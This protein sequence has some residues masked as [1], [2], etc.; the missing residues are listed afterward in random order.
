MG[1][2]VANFKTDGYVIT[3]AVEDPIT[4]ENVSA[5]IIKENTPI[6]F[7]FVNKDISA[8][9]GSV[10]NLYYRKYKGKNIIIRSRDFPYIPTTEFMAIHEDTYDVLKATNRLYDTLFKYV[11]KYNIE[12]NGEIVES[13]MS[14]YFKVVNEKDYEDYK[15]AFEA[16]FKHTDGEEIKRP[17]KQSD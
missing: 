14:F 1:D 12:K 5:Y 10:S 6:V 13:E 11:V 7:S 4:R 16:T 9:G 8:N 3:G 15:K 2:V 17:I